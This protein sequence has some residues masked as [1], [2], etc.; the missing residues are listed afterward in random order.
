MGECA[1][2]SRASVS[3]RAV[4]CTGAVADVDFRLWPYY[5]RKGNAPR[6]SVTSL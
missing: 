5:Y 6:A 1:S 3:L 2:D 4:K